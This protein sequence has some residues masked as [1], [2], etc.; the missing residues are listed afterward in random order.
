ME[1]D[2]NWLGIIGT[3]LLVGGAALVLNSAWPIV[4]AGAIMIFVAVLP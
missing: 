2:E 3:I 4:I 1:R